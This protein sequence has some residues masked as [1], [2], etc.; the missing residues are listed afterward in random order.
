MVSSPDRSRIRP[1]SRKTPV[2]TQLRVNCDAGD[3][4]RNW[5]VGALAEDLDRLAKNLAAQVS[6][7]TM[8]GELVHPTLSVT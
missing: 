5:E 3:P 7:A 4:L 6:I 1:P 2:Y 8:S